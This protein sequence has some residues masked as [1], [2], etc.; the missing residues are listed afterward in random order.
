MRTFVDAEIVGWIGRL[1]A[2]GAQHVAALFEMDPAL[3]RERL[4]CLVSEGRL[5]QAERPDGQDLYWASKA[6]LSEHG[7]DRLGVWQ[8]DP[9]DLDHAWTVAGVAVELTLGLIDWDVLSAREVALMDADSGE[10]FASVR[11]GEDG[12][13]TTRVPALVLCSPLG[14]AVPI[15]IEPSRDTAWSSLVSICRGWASARHVNRVYWLARTGPGLRVRRAVREAHASDRV[16]VLGLDDVALLTASE[17]AQEDAI[18][19]L[20]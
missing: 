9:N 14:R 2:A 10:L 15:E 20:L 19:A 4:E 7:L 1:G 18:D 13:R 17:A 12:Q 8:L 5:E 3:V 16:T 11:V 6:G